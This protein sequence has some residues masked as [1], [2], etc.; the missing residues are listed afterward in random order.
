MNPIIRMVRVSST[1]V[2]LRCR[3]AAAP[4]PETGQAGPGQ[5]AASHSPALLPDG[6]MPERQARAEGEGYGDKSG[7]TD[8]YA[9]GHKTGYD[10]GYESGYEAGHEFGQEAGRKEGR[11]AVHEQG[12]A[13]LENAAR[14]IQGL[15]EKIDL[16]VQARLDTAEDAAI[17]IAYEAVLRIIGQS[18]GQ[19]AIVRDIVRVVVDK[20][21]DSRQ[22]T[23]RV[24]PAD[25]TI[26]ADVGVSMFCRHATV[27]AD[28]RVRLGGCIVD[29]EAG[30]LDGRL[31][32]QLMLLKELLLELRKTGQDAS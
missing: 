31:E 21:R 9:T 19:P 6:F 15:L 24:A 26:L 17:E 28:E 22:I 27:V 18:I 25:F 20:V 16:S 11:E 30:S 32:V 2:A 7:N 8:G 23:I 12:R 3:P 29:T 4:L 5:D 10:A 13:A 1:A 14:E